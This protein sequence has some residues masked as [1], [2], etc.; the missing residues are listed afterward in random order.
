MSALKAPAPCDHAGNPDREF[1]VATVYGG[2]CATVD[3]AHIKNLVDAV[4]SACGL[5]CGWSLRLQVFQPPYTNKADAPGG[6][7]EFWIEHPAHPALMFAVEFAGTEHSRL[8]FSDL[9]LASMHEAG[10]NSDPAEWAS[11]ACFD[12]LWLFACNVAERLE[13]SK[14]HLSYGI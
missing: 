9:S 12:E 7:M 1:R 14:L 2:S 13:V 3:K 4:F 5:R 10:E 6:Y 8:V 11:V